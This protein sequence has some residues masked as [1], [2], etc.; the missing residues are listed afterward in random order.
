MADRTKL[1]IAEKMKEL[2]KHKELSRIRTTEI[3]EAAEIDRSTFYYHF[4]DKY[5]LVAWIFYNG[6]SGINVIDPREAAENMRKMKQEMLFF[7]R[8]YED[9]SQN[10]LM[11]YIREYY[12]AEFVRAAENITGGKLSAQL[13][14]SIRLYACGATEACR[15]W[16][17][18]DHDTPAE[19]IVEMMFQSMPESMRRIYFG[20][21]ES[22]SKTDS[23]AG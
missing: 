22:V 19:E 5:D 4:R 17:L 16:I 21:G 23:P 8:A 9:Q 18:D 15:E 11:K 1:W 20:S 2:M 6:A 10:A 12:T 3:C 14:F 7:R 13:L